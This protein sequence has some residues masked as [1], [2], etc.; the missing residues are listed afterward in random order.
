MPSM[1]S[2]LLHALKTDCM[3]L[4]GYSFKL[5]RASQHITLLFEDY[6]WDRQGP[7]YCKAEE[8]EIYFSENN[9]DFEL[10]DILPA[11]TTSYPIGQLTDGEEYYFKTVLKH[12][13][14]EADTLSTIQGIPGEPFTSYTPL[15]E[16]IPYIIDAF[17]FSFDQAYSAYQLP[18]KTWVWVDSNASPWGF[19][20]IENSRYLKWLPNRNA[21]IYIKMENEEN[22]AR[23]EKI[24]LYDVE[25]N[26]SEI[27]MDASNELFYFWDIEISKD[28]KNVFFKSNEN[29]NIGSSL[30]SNNWEVWKLD[31]STLAR[32]KITNLEKRD[33]FDPYEFKLDQGDT[34]Q[35]FIYARDNG[36]LKI[37]K[38][39]TPTESL[40]EVVALGTVFDLGNKN[41]VSV[42]PSG[43]KFLYTDNLTGTSEIY[44]IES[45]QGRGVQI[46]DHLSDGTSLEIPKN[47][48][49][50]EENRTKTYA[51]YNGVYQFL[52]FNF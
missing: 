30:T 18:K 15:G 13:T 16:N 14:L 49:W 12:C 3:Y 28:G 46:T 45:G 22:S 39:T 34:P 20:E 24:M 5:E 2:N 43:N 7:E 26:N 19:T 27:L 41:L 38:A 51:Y 31:L 29:L 44:L 4:N 1:V 9:L 6:N 52:E 25:S 32:Q 10:L 36:D 35:I 11:S 48:I 47:F 21:F 17:E 33:F 37:F 40:I 50:L 8:F 23:T 42:S